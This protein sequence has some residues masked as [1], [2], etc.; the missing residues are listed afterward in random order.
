MPFA[1]LSY[2][3]F[4]INVRAA[5]VPSKRCKVGAEITFAWQQVKET[6]PVVRQSFPNRYVTPKRTPC[7]WY[8]PEA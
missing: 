1:N 2:F 7:A 5:S 4:E 6:R 3:A 8:A